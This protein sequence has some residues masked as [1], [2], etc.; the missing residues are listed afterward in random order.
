MKS[1]FIPTTAETFE[2]GRAEGLK[3]AF[4]EIQ[5]IRKV[6]G[7]S[8]YLDGYIQGRIAAIESRMKMQVVQGSKRDY[9]A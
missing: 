3:E 9:E 1:N 7:D 4:L 6:M 5:S 2:A 8:E